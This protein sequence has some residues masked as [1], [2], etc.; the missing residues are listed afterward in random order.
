MNL[1]ASADIMHKVKHV[2]RAPLSLYLNGGNR[3]M[4]IK[5]T[6]K[7]TGARSRLDLRLSASIHHEFLLLP[8][9]DGGSVAARQCASMPSSP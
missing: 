3:S 5:L 4:L 7:M 6:A 1:G 2:D 9:P 8:D